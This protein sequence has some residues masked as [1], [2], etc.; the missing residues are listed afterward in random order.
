MQLSPQ[1]SSRPKVILLPQRERIFDPSSVGIDSEEERKRKKRLI[2]IAYARQKTE[3]KVGQD[4]QAVSEK[5]SKINATDGNTSKGRERI[6][7]LLR[8]AKV[9]NPLVEIITEAQPGIE[10][11]LA[12]R[13][14]NK[15]R[16][17]FVK[18][19]QLFWQRSPQI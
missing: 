19:L 14:R 5:K 17:G 3:K 11:Q 18:G 12:Q 1:E 13:R 10:Q 16:K 9:T 2:L 6:S 4:K 15:L 8:I 7:G